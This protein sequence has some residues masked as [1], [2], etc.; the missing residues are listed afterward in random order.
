VRSLLAA[1]LL[2]ASPVAAQQSPTWVSI[3]A[4]GTLRFTMEGQ[5]HVNEL[6]ASETW[7]LQVRSTDAQGLSTDYEVAVNV[8]PQPAATLSV[9]TYTQNC[10]KQAPETRF[11]LSDAHLTVADSSK[12]TPGSTI[13]VDGAVVLTCPPQPP[14]QPGCDAQ[15]IEWDTAANPVDHVIAGTV[16]W[17]D[18][19]SDTLSIPFPLSKVCEGY[20]APTAPT[21]YK[22]TLFWEPP[23]NNIKEVS[24][25]VSYDSLIECA[26]G[27]QRFFTREANP[28]GLIKFYTCEPK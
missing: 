24:D 3:D 18:G 17:N 27:A 28:Q 7:K 12:V 21:A 4:D 11:S 14:A 16:K 1:L 19:T 15:L 9:N 10:H 26:A 22:M 23:V 6:T 25:D 13:S 8:H 5:K 20:V 2:L